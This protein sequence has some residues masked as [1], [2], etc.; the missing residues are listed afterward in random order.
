MIPLYPDSFLFLIESKR[1]KSAFK[2]YKVYSKK[3]QGREDEEEGKF[4]R[5]MNEKEEN[6][7]FDDENLKIENCKLHKE[8]KHQKSPIL[9][10]FIIM[11]FAL[12]NSFLA[13]GIRYILPKTLTYVY[14]IKNYNTDENTFKENF[15]SN[16]GLVSLEL[17]ISSISAGIVSFMTGILI[18][19]T[20]FKR[21]KLLRMAIFMSSLISAMA[22]FVKTKID[23]FS[24]TLKT[25]IILQ[26]QIIDIYAIE[27]FEVKKR[28]MLLSIYNILQSTSGFLSPYINDLIT[29]YWFRLNYLVFAILLMVC[30]IM[31]L[32]LGR[33]KI[34]NI[35]A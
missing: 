2:V 1:Y 6:K 35:L 31:S 23:L 21:L 34:K 13:Q 20:Y 26:D 4:L 17:Q 7:K 11:S 5:I 33:Q 16:A 32:F 25:V 18:E 10:Y 12:L 27:A 19:N 28:V 3:G 24:C 9:E 14:H 29:F 8:E 15:S 22:F 30:F